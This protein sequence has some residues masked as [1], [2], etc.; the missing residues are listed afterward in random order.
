MRTI[1]DKNI[2]G[3]LENERKGIVIIDN[4]TPISGADAINIIEINIAIIAIIIEG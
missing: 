1:K 2:V 4:N 3:I